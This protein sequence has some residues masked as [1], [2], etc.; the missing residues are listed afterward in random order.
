MFNVINIAKTYNKTTWIVVLMN[1]IK[2]KHHEFKESSSMS[3]MSKV[4]NVIKAAVFQMLKIMKR[5]YN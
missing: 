4:S 3:A 5:Y 2:E 1:F